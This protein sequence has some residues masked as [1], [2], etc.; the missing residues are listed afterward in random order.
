M[1][2]IDLE[3]LH[4]WLCKCAKKNMVSHLFS[5]FLGTSTAVLYQQKN[6]ASF[7]MTLQE[8]PHL[9]EGGVCVEVLFCATEFS[10]QCGSMKDFLSHTACLPLSDGE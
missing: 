3:L 5:N 7:A 8:V 2:Q 10:A 9:R 1:E 6:T 4:W